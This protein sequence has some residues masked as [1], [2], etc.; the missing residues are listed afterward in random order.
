MGKW[1]AEFDLE[2]GDT[3]PEHMDL[4]YKGGRIDFH[5]R[6]LEQ[7]PTTKNDLGADAVSRQAV[8]DLMMQKWGENFSGDDAM[9]ESID[10]IRELPSVTPQEPILN[11]IRAEIIDKAKKELSKWRKDLNYD[12]GDYCYGD[13]TTRNSLDVAID[14]MRKYQKIE[15]ILDDCDLEAWELVKKIREVVEDGKID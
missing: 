13:D 9:Q 10:A 3:M 1:I 4:E 12:N 5:C 7:E 8:L 11:K 6:P 14:I 15:Q 2:D